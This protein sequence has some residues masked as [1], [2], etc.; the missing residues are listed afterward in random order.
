M[1]VRAHEDRGTA[2]AVLAA[3][4]AAVVAVALRAVLRHALVALAVVLLRTP[5]PPPRHL[6]P[7]EA[8]PF[9]A[10]VAVRVGVEGPYWHHRLVIADCDLVAGA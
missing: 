5:L 7:L 1:G 3:A 2:V 4:L 8:R 6:P 9:T 10:Q